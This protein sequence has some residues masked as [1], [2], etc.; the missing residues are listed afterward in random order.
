MAAAILGYHPDH[1]SDSRW[2]HTDVLTWRV[3][4]PPCQLVALSGNDALDL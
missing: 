4:Q 2:H 3:V 1:V